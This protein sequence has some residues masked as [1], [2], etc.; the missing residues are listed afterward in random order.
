ME[1]SVDIRVHER[2]RKSPNWTIDSDLNGN[3]TLES[4]QRF[5]K[6]ALISIHQEVL[7]EEIGRGFPTNHLTIVDGKH[8]RPIDSVNPF[9]SIRSLKKQ[10]LTK[11]ILEIYASLILLSPVD[12]GLYRK[13]HYVY[14]ND[15]LVATDLSSLRAWI[16]LE[17]TIVDKDQLR[18]V[19]VTH[20]AGKLERGGI[21]SRGSARKEGKGRKR[22]GAVPIVKKPNGTYALTAQRMKGK[23]GKNTLIAFEWRPG[24]KFN[25]PVYHRAKREYVYPTILIYIFSSGVS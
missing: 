4:I 7:K 12:T 23:Y 17:P 9:G 10:S 14:K 16:D 13:S 20:Y 3:Q 22:K 24:S 18:I 25:I 1:F 6:T 21:T 11:I 19:N 5:T 15:S 8:N 2:G